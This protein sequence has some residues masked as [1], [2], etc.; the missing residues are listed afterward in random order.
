LPIVKK[1][2]WTWSEHQEAIFDNAKNS[3]RHTLIEAKAGSA[4]STS[5]L[6]SLEY[7]PAN[8]TALL[9]AFNKKIAEELKAKAPD[10][11]NGHIATF[12]SIGLKAVFNRFP[13][14]KVNDQKMFYILDKVVGKD[15]NLWQLKSQ[16]RKCVSLCKVSLASTISEIENVIDKYDIDI[17]IDLYKF[18]DYVSKAMLKSYESTSEVDFNDMVW[19]PHVHDLTLPKY[20]IVLIDEAQDLDKAQIKLALGS[21]KDKGRI[22]A[23]LDRYQNIYEFKAATTEIIDILLNNYNAETLPLP[24]SYRCPISV[25][26]EAKKLVPDIQAWSEAK[27]GKVEEITNGK[28]KEM[29]KPGNVILSRF[30][31]PLVKLAFHFIGAGKPAIILGKDIG[32]NLLALIKKSKK[33]TIPSLQTWLTSWSKKEITRLKKNN[34]EEAIEAVEDKVACVEVLCENCSSIAE[35]KKK[36]ETMFKDVDDSKVITI[37]S[38]HKF[39]GKEAKCVFILKNTLRYFNQNEKNCVY[40]AITRSQ[41]E[42]YY[43]T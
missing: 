17:D 5:L 8:K 22:I 34:K 36:I 24:I 12:H 10:C 2:S 28:M 23:Y 39:K 14:A 37:S 4:K 43:V 27:Q 30:N 3:T 35:I 1:Q 7:F 13:S 41:D 16:V 18:I 42:L 38:I 6:K 32:I 26:K 11:H 15:K 25:I 31:A 20:D 19:F 33:K 9:T 21:V 40:V 29:A